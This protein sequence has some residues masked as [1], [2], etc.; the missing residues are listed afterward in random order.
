MSGISVSDSAGLN[1]ALRDAKAGDTIYLAG[2]TYS[3]ISANGLLKGGA[4]TVTSADP[5]RPAVLTDLNVMNSNGFTFTNLE[6][7]PKEGGYFAYLVNSSQNITFSNLDIH[8]TM[9]GTP[10]GDAWGISILKSSGIKILAS[11]FQQLGRGVGVGSSHDVEISGNRLHDLQSDGINVA[12][13]QNIRIIGNELKSFFPLEAD[14]ADGIQFWTAG[15]TKASENIVI[16]NNMISRGAGAGFQGIFMKDE[17]GTLPYKNV[18]IT[19]NILVGT[20]YHGIGVFHSENLTV[21]GNQ[22]FSYPGGTNL[23]WMLIQNADGAVVLDNTAIQ[24][25]FDNVTNMSKSGNATNSPVTDGGEAALQAWAA[26][27]G[28]QVAPTPPVEQAPTIDPTS[29][30]PMIPSLG[31]GDLYQVNAYHSFGG[32]EI[33]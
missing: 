5:A 2:G 26:K 7:A 33:Y 24:Y 15:T 30:N 11:E 19:D 28:H 25:G 27:V 14:H 17:V 29:Y 18:A 10:H 16:A 21:T 13:G 3:G 32:W 22:L 12:D 4:V 20:G 8:G 9:N 6:F 1:T 23:N 31:Y